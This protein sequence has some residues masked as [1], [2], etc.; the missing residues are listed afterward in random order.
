MYRRLMTDIKVK[1]MMTHIYWYL[2]TA[3]T[4]FRP[5]QGDFY[6]AMS[7]SEIQSNPNPFS[8]FRPHLPN[9]L[10]ALYN[11]GID[12]GDVDDERDSIILYM[13]DNSGMA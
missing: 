13:S 1:K 4:G 3:A 8:L 10:P 2:D 6:I 12:F 5:N 9:D 11:Y 7:K